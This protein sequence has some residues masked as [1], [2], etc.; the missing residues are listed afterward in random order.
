LGQ[1][2]TLLYKIVAGA[3]SV[4]SYV[5]YRTIQQGLKQGTLNQDTVSAAKLF[6]AADYA[7][8][9]PN[10]EFTAWSPPFDDKTENL[11]DKWE[12]CSS[13]GTTPLWASSLGGADRRVYYN[14][15]ESVVGDN[16][17][18]VEHTS[19]CDLAY[20]AGVR[21]VDFL[22]VVTN[23]LY[24]IEAAIKF[25]SSTDTAAD[26][27]CTV[28]QKDKATTAASIGSG[29]AA[30]GSGPGWHYPRLYVRPGADAA[31]LR[32]DIVGKRRSPA[33]SSGKAYFDYARCCR[34]TDAFRAYR[35][36][37]NIS[38]ASGGA[39]LTWSHATCQ[40]E[41]YDLNSNYTSGS[42]YFTAPCDGIWVFTAQAT[43]DGVPSGDEVGVCVTSGGA[44]G[45][46]TILAQDVRGNAAG[47]ARD[48]YVCMTTAP[49][50]LSSGDV[51]RMYV[52]WADI[53]SAGGSLAVLYGT[54][55]T[56]FA[57]FEK[58]EL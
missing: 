55:T 19:T 16:S 18:E 30:A 9:L 20:T 35:A 3:A 13:G 53:G 54:Y 37:S 29:S 24:L 12:L 28:L 49:L 47:V 26:L 51:I 14:T 38:I 46:G 31:Y 36:S 7:S 34:S 25:D 48:M 1:T 56:Y 50:Q 21:T 57:G 11:P 32:I 8:L 2:E 4:S 42:Q 45:A 23:Q 6:T 58:K 39:T 33:S 52:G 43:F 44:P 5:D 27:T 10:G 15:S 41:S 40:T 17:V 22:P